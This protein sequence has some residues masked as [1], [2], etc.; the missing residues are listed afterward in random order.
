[1]EICIRQTRS[2]Y[3]KNPLPSMSIPI[4]GCM[5][6]SAESDLRRSD[7]EIISAGW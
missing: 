5:A 1:M 6:A 2:G 3:R 7:V 4:Q